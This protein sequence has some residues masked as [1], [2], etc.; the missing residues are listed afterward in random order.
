M[1]ANR[2][3]WTPAWLLVAIVCVGVLAVMY[4]YGGEDK[5][6]EPDTKRDKASTV[7]TER[8]DM[9]GE[10]ITVVVDAGHGGIDP[11]KVGVH[12]EK[13]KDINLS[14]AKKLEEKLT[15]QGY[16]VVMT[17]TEDSGMYSDGDSNKKMADMK[18][19]IA[20][21]TETEPKLV[22]SIHQNS[23]TQPSSKGAQVFYYE[24]SEEG[25]V[26][27]QTLQETIKSVIGDGNKRQAKANTNYY[28]LLH[29]PCTMVIVECGFLS[30]PEEALLLSDDSYQEKMMDAICQGINNY[31]KSED[32][33]NQ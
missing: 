23:F 9:A 31:V 7:T 11:G 13:E 24:K 18:A 2:K 10:G 15:E 29:T 5:N 19:R 8:P 4:K 21:I 14:M 27:A 3:R 25:K 1:F 20:L 30:N 22:V 26:L 12:D 32:K 28:M 17:R 33:E 6:G 16:T